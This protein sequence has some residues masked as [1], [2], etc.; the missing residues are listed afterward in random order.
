M[1]DYRKL[2]AWRLAKE[3]V[4]ISHPLL[5]RLPL[6]ERFALTNQWRRAG[7]SVVLNIAEGASRHGAREF[8][9]FLDIARGS[10]HELETIFDIVVALEYLSANELKEV[11]E[12]R[13]QCARAVYGLLKRMSVAS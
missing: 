7:Y 1:G 11:A 4:I 10:L 2:D 12:K 8:R 9:R 6:D 5:K 3:L 13:S